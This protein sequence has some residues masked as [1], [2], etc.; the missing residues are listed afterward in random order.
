MRQHILRASSF[1]AWSVQCLF[2]GGM[3]EES[4]YLTSMCRQWSG[5]AKRQSVLNPALSF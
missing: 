3:A 1:C 2:G 4:E 5:L